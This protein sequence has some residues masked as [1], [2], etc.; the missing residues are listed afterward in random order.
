MVFGYIDMKRLIAILLSCVALNVNATKVYVST[1]GSDD[2]GDGSFLNPWATWQKGFTEITAGDTLYIRGGTYTP[3]A[4]YQDPRYFGVVVNGV[5]GTSGNKITVLN[6]PGEVPVL[7]CRNIVNDARRVG[8]G[9]YDCDHWILRGLNVT[10]VDQ[11]STGDVSVGVLLYGCDNI[12]VDECNMYNNQGMGLDVSTGSSNILILN[13]D[14]YENHDPYS[15]YGSADG[16]GS[17]DNTYQASIIFRGCR[18][19]NNSD[20]GFDYY[21]DNAVVTTDGCWAWH[22]GYRE[23]G[24]TPGGDGSGFKLG[25][26]D[27][28]PADL[29]RILQNNLAFSNRR[30]GINSNSA[31]CLINV[32]NNTIYANGLHGIWIFTEDLAYIFRNNVS[33]GNVSGYDYLSSTQVNYTID[34]NSYDP[35]WQPAGV[36]VTAADFVSITP[37]GVD[38]A[39]QSDGSL[40]VI[41][42]LH[43]AADSDLRAAGVAIAGLTTDGDGEDWEDPPSIGAFEYGAIGGERFGKNRQGVMLKSRDGRMMI[44][45]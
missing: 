30:A 45:N 14:A 20:D 43:L 25:I 18:S 44:Y 3:A 39:R 13:C 16:F 22:N 24:V 23:D 11:H 31:N 38:G 12:L 15:S 7:D 19:W 41:T 37:T 29:L 5:S 10:R 33:F 34:H 8:I 36:V 42:F 35:E 40:P 9:L 4:T 6:Y 27:V 1:T 32:Y 21:G 2:T 26:T 17:N 28:H